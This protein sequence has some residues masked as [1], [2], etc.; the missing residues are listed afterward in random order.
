M[1]Y[2]AFAYM[3]HEGLLKAAAKRDVNQ[4]IYIYVYEYTH[5]IDILFITSTTQMLCHVCL[6]LHNVYS[7]LFLFL[8]R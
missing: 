6:K 3:N 1:A 8:L 5:Y 2:E 4:Y 7:L